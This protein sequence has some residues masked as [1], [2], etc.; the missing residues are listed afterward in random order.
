MAKEIKL[1]ELVDTVGQ[2]QRGMDEIL[3]RL[4]GSPLPPGGGA[5]VAP[6]VTPSP[7]R[8]PRGHGASLPPLNEDLGGGDAAAAPQ[9]PPI[10]APTCRSSSDA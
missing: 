5:H 9:L 1:Q 6:P 3:R 8:G 2:L 7:A 4:G 10:T